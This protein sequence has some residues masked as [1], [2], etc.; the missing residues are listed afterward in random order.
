MSKPERSCFL[1]TC[2][3]MPFRRPTA[4]RLSTTRVPRSTELDGTTMERVRLLIAD[5]NLEICDILENFFALTDEVAVC[6][7]A[8]DG[9]EALFY[10]A[11]SDPDVML[12]DLIMPKLDGIS[13]LEKLSRTVMARRP[14][15]IVTSAVG[16]ENFTAAALALGADY[17]MIKPYNLSALLSRVCTAAAK[18]APAPNH[19]REE[20]LSVSVSRA[21]LDLGIPTHMLG[22]RYCAAAVE[23]L[24]REN[25]PCSMIKEVYAAIAREFAT[26]PECVEGAIRKGIR[27]SFT[28]EPGPLRTLTG[29]DEAPA[30]G[31]FLTSLAQHIRL[32]A[33]NGGTVL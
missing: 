12:L 3:K 24:L 10:I 31:R 8:H 33:D 20:T 4:G 30:N 11:Q 18:N 22:Y 25:R 21:L 19:R 2:S 13:V 7:V 14:R 23:L 9:E 27:H 6:A 15:V 5:D 16:Q 32:N 29:A 17:Y 1:P 28:R 26:T